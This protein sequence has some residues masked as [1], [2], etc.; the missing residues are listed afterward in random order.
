[1]SVSSQIRQRKLHSEKEKLGKDDLD[2]RETEYMLY[3]LASIRSTMMRDERGVMGDV[4]RALG[5]S[6]VAPPI[7]PIHIRRY[8]GDYKGFGTV[9][10]LVTFSHR[11]GA[12][13]R[14]SHGCRSRA[15]IA[16][17]P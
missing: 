4:A 10:E 2:A 11:S 12:G 3:T 17:R 9:E 14:R 16:V 13:E 5:R 7:D 6:L 1:M 15:R 8:V